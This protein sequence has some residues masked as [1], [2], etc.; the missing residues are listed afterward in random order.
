MAF[1][2]SVYINSNELKSLDAETEC[3]RCILNAADIVVEVRIDFNYSSGY[4]NP[5]RISNDTILKRS[6]YVE[7]INISFKNE[8]RDIEENIKVLVT[9]DQKEAIGHL[10]KKIIYRDWNERYEKLAFESTL[11]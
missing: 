3:L 4:A 1:S 9:K 2:T 10:T 6:S 8:D 5:P 7:I 11:K